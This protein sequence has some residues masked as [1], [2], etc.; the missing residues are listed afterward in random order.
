MQ[1]EKNNKNKTPS[2]VEALEHFPFDTFEEMQKLTKEGVAN[3]EVN[4]SVALKWGMGGKHQPWWLRWITL[5]LIS[6]PFLSGIG[7]L[8]FIFITGKWALLLALPILFI[9]FFLL[10]PSAAVFGILR[11]GFI[12]LAFAG[13]AWG[14]LKGITW[15]VATTIPIVLIWYSLRTVYRKAVKYLINAV[16][17]NE[18]LLCL[19][20]STKALNIRFYNGDNYWADW[21]REGGEVYRYDKESDMKNSHKE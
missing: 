20:W 14:I 19:L 9:S 11:S 21:K 18:D 4:R 2:K 16:R 7:F 3:I 10:Q 6:I 12:F 1:E 17:N 8:I 15:L 5:L 13:L